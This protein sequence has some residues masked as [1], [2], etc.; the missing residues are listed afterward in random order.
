M[1][2]IIDGYNLIRQSRRLSAIEEVDLQAGRDAL[3]NALAAYRKMKP[4]PVTI[5]F[6]GGD[7][8]PGLPRRDRLR[9]IHMRFSRA[10]ELADDVIKRIIVREKAKALVV[11]SDMDIV[12]YAHS[13]GAV[14]VSSK[15]FDE[16]LEMAQYTDLKGADDDLP[17]SGWQ[18]TTKKRGP[19]RRLPKRKR[20]MNKVLSKL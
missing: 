11:S 10:G 12:S 3:V 1:H 20:R 13:K 8:V 17:E 16:R 4:F 7:A 2:I 5:V 19:S 14:T 9:G 18:A 15:E 6:D